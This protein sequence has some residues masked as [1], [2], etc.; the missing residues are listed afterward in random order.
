MLAQIEILQIC[1]AIYSSSKNMNRILEE[2]VPH[3]YKQLAFW[4]G[5]FV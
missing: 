5:M 2:M 4:R 3:N 1:I